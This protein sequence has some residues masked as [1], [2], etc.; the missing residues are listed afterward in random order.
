MTHRS[1]RGHSL[2]ELLV[3]MGLAALVGAIVLPAVLALQGRGLAEV[4]RNDLQGRAGRLLRFV[5]QDLR[6]AAFLVGASPHRPGGAAPVLVHD[7]LPGDP[8]V[9]LPHALLAEDGDLLGHDAVTLVRADSFFPPLHLAQAAGSGATTLRL[10]RRPNQA[11]GSSREI[12]PAPEAISHVVLANQRHCYPVGTAGQTL[13]LLDGLAVAAP[14]ATELLGLRAYRFHLDRSGRLRRDDFTSDEIIGDGVDGL[15]FEYLLV[16]GRIVD[17]PTD[18]RAVRAIRLSLLV[19]DL[20]PDRG[21]RDQDVYRLGNRD[22]GPYR[23]SFR[24]VVASTMVEVI[25]HALP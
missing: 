12:H 4:S 9:A 19:R 2:A 14:A 1:C 20:R 23:D 6:T 18:P 8:A 16:D 3:A 11:P 15:Q 17:L 5:S 24:R 21:Y 13:Q 7:S 22:Y 10:N 25:N